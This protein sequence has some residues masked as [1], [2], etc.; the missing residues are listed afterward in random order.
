MRALVTGGAGFIGGHLVAALAA[1]P[2]A[3]VRVLDNL[4]TG[5]RANLTGAP[6]DLIEGDLCDS[7]ALRRALDGVEVV[8]HMAA[9]VSVPESMRDPERAVRVNTLGTLGLL[10]AAATARVRRIVFSSSCAVYGSPERMPVAESC[11]VNPLSPYAL[12]KYDGECLLRAL[13]PGWGVEAVVLRYFNVYGPRQDP[14]SPYAAAVPIFTARARRGEPLTIYGDG[15]Q[16]RDF[17]HVGDVVA[18]N[19]AAATLPPD[20]YNVGSGVSVSVLALAR[21]IARLAG[22]RSALVHAPS[23]AGEVRDSRADNARLTAQG[24]RPARTL[25]EGLRELLAEA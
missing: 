19:L 3:R 9:Q 2:G 5:R 14:Q 6:C 13:A 22:G 20:T 18:A 16:T 12:T 24:W 21:A 15:A 25:E 23:R 11:P 8:F 1:R 4:S 7:E 17:I 10:R